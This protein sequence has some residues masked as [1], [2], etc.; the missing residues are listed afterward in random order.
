MYLP[1]RVRFAFWILLVFSVIQWPIGVLYA[2]YRSSA[3]EDAQRSQLLDAL[4]SDDAG[5]PADPLRVRLYDADAQ[6]RPVD[7]PWAPA[8]NPE[9]LGTLPPEASAALSSGA[10]AAAP[11]DGPRYWALAVRRAEG[12]TLPVEPAYRVAAV[13]AGPARAQRRDVWEA[14]LIV[15]SGGTLAAAVAGVFIGAIATE[16]VDRLREL[17][18][19]LTPES[20]VRN[21]EI[22][23]E[24]NDNP[25]LM[26]DLEDTRRRLREAFA[27]QE[28]FLSNVSHE[29]K[30]P[31]AVLMIEADTLPREG[32][33]P[34][35]SDFVDGVREE[36][37]KLGR[38]IESFLTLTRVKEGA[39]PMRVRP[40]AFNDLV[41]DSLED[42]AVMAEQQRVRLRPSLLDRDDEL[43]AAIRGEPEL[44][45]TMLNNL[46]RNA[47]RHSPKDTTVDI[48]LS[49]T[50]DRVRISV[51]DR[52]PGIPPDR[53]KT[54]F[55]RFAQASKSNRKGRGHGLGLAIAQGIAELHG[56]EIEAENNPNAGCTFLVSFPRD[57]APST[58][59]TPAPARD[60]RA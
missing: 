20:I 24:L 39:D 28:R 43:D 51:R 8:L 26:R 60:A 29:I 47:L 42:C 56:G 54:I 32:L 1:L 33:T 53:L 55:D 36:M 21:D 15:C 57:P 31:I 58:D 59:N 13:D 11:S 18:H 30:T 6:G 50:P 35:A 12:A 17:T 3:I 2:F 4:S 44:L 19:Q 40:Y 14:I 45:C 10:I 7:A 34:E 9:V 16:S 46:I 5:D 22:E 25:G 48:S 23:S 38:L 27:A 52:G 49:A 37:L 41:M